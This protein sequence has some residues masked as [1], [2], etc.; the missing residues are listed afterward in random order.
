[1]SSK[2]VRSKPSPAATDS[3][4][5]RENAKRALIVE[6]LG[7]SL[8]ALTVELE[9]MGY[10][11][12]RASDPSAVR[13]LVGSLR[14]LSLVVVNGDSFR[15]DPARLVGAIKEHHPDLP[16]LWMQADRASAPAK[17][18]C[19]ATDLERLSA[20]IGRM[21]RE[22]F[23]SPD[24]VR[25]VVSGA[26]GVLA[27]FGAPAMASEPG[28]RSSLSL[29]SE[30]AAFVFFY[31]P[32]LAGH[33][34]LTA[35]TGDVASVYRAQFSGAPPGQDDVEDFL[36]E[37]TNRIS[38]QIKRCVDPDAGE[39]HMGLP[40]FIRGEGTSFRYKAGTPTLAVDLTSGDRKFHVELCLYRF[41]HGMIR[42]VESPTQMQAG[43]VNFL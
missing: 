30:L 32:G 43:V 28:V 27:D 3:S 24:F 21:A 37:M 8:N 17:V 33:T 42:G 25:A 23:Y 40:Y 39:C 36:G 1:L 12:L 11:V 4:Q 18:D 20:R 10:E 2:R 16:I 5:R 22:T 26:Q 38:G 19:V 14:R 29:L 41:D 35:T 13:G 31:G 6:R 9:R 15:S 7:G 34:L